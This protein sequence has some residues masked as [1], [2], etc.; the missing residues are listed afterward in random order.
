MVHTPGHITTTVVYTGMYTYKEAESVL[1]LWNFFLFKKN[2]FCP[3]PARWDGRD[4]TLS[5]TQPRIQ[6][7]RLLAHSPSLC[8]T[9][10][11]LPVCSDVHLPLPFS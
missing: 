11:I 1:L 6:C 5:G 7:D 3:F 4:P 10:Y 2:F 9:G 8:T